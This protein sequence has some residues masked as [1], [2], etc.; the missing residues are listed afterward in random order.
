MGEFL[1]DSNGCRPASYTARA[2]TV[3]NLIE[4][5]LNTQ[6]IFIGLLVLFAGVIFFSSMLNTSLIG[7]AE[8]HREVATLR[9]LGYTEYQIGGYFLR[10]SM[11]VNSL[12]TLLGLPV[13]YALTVWLTTSTTRK[14]S[15]SPGRP[16]ECVDRRVGLAI[17]FAWPP[18]CSCKLRSIGSIGA[19]R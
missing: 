4:T 17:V 15:A 12:G 11:V 3:R 14:C 19:R 5:V 7:L 8:R 10:E 16:A 2:N 1:R 9:V 18:T 6:M 13:G